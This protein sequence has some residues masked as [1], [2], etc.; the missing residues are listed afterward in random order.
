MKNII[1]Q[2]IINIRPMADQ[3]KIKGKA[4]SFFYDGEIAS[5]EKP[6][7]TILSLNSYIE[8]EDY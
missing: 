5:I 4:D 2:K 8:N 7:G 6:N 3:E 1:G